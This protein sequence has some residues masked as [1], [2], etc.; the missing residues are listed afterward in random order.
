[1][2][3]GI[4]RR[5]FM[6]LVAASSG[7]FVL[8]PWGLVPIPEGSLGPEEK[9]FAQTSPFPRAQTVLIRILTGRVGTPDDFNQWV[10]WKSPDRGMQNLADE[11]LWSVDFA[12]GKIINGVAD[13]D[14]KYTPD[15]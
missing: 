6:K 11:P 3:Q 7:A 14:A 4:K 13:G 2:S 10:G 15:F 1:M 9:A 5:D 12:S 8:A